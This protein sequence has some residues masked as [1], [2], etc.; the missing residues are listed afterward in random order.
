MELK[1]ICELARLIVASSAWS[2]LTVHRRDG[3]HEHHQGRKR[4][5][6]CYVGRG[7]DFDDHGCESGH[8][9][10]YWHS[11][12][13]PFHRNLNDSWVGCKERV[14]DQDMNK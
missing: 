13:Q 6:R 14:E 4:R 7:A 2:L 11:G 12:Y 9:F 10:E 1:A 5:D 3:P 8:L